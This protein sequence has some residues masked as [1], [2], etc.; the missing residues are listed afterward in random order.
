MLFPSPGA[1]Y[2]SAECREFVRSRQE[3]EHRLRKREAL[4]AYKTA[5]G[6]DRC[7]YNKSG[8]ALDFHH[9]DDNKE[10][11]FT[12]KAWGTPAFISEM[13]KCILLCAN[14]HREEHHAEIEEEAILVA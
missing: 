1:K 3:K 12:V 2:C 6:C 10:R 7:G 9:T 5:R 4:W 13:E 11:R 14:C 8:A